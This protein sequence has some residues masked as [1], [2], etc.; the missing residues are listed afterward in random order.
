MCSH[1]HTRKVENRPSKDE[2]LQDFRELKSFVKIGAK[3]GVSDN[4]IR[5]WFIAIGLPSKSKELK[6]IL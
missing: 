2:L 5:K 1:K 6:L 3:Y 4:A